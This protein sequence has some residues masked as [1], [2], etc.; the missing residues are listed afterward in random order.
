[1]TLFAAKA[2]PKDQGK[3]ADTKV[4]PRNWKVIGD[5]AK[6]WTIAL[7]KANKRQN[8]IDDTHKTEVVKDSS[9]ADNRY[10][11]SK[12]PKNHVDQVMKSIQFEYSK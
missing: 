3:H 6:N 8:R 5:H 11:K 4:E 7:N 1:M 2:K 10:P 9:K 12:Y